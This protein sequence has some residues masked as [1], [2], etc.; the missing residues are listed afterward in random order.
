MPSVDERIVNMKMDN[1]Q[2]QS[3]ART[4]TSIFDKLKA[5]LNFTGAGKG[6]TD[7]QNKLSGFKADG[8]LNAASAVGSKFSAMSIASIAAIASIATKA[9]DVGL[10][11]TKALTIK[12]IMDGFNEYELKMD[13]I[14][15][16]LANTAKHGTKLKEVNSV[17]DELNTYADR[18]IYNFGDMTKN[19]GLFTNAGIKVKDASDMIKGFSNVA[20]ASGTSAQGA[21]GAAYQLS[22]ALSAGTIRLM[23]WRSLTNVGMGNKN[24]QEGIVELA[25]SMGVLDKAGISS[26]E[27]MSDFNGS[28]EKKWLSAD[29]MSKYLRIMGQEMTD[30]EMKTLGL[31]KAQIDMFKK[32][33]QTAFD[34]ANKV[35]TFSKLV[36]TLKESAGSGWS[37]TFGIVLGDFDQ[38]TELFTNINDVLSGSLGKMADARNDLLKGWVKMGGRD[39]VIKGLGNM[40]NGLVALMKPVQEAFRQIFPPTTAKQ[41]Y[42][43]THSFLEFTKT[44]TVGATTANNIKRTFAGVFAIFSIG[45]SLVKALAGVLGDLFGIVMS[46]SGSFLEVTAG[47]GDWLVALDQ[48][49]KKGD[50]FEKFFSSLGNIL[51]GVVAYIR[52]VASAIADMFAGF[53][54]GGV[55]EGLGRITDRLAP[56]AGAGGLVAKVWD[57]LIDILGKTGEILAPLG[58]AIGTALSGIGDAIAKAFAAGDFNS[59]YDALNSGLLIGIVLLIKK[60]LG[61]GLKIDFGDGLGASIKETFGALT[62]TLTAMQTQIQAK[63]L[64]TIAGAIAILTVS[65]VALSL[66]DSAALSKSLTAMA[67]AFGQLMVAMSIL[68]KITAVGG[69]TKIPLIAAGMIALSVAVLIL[70]AAVR[71]LSGLSWEE[72]A[73]G[74]GGVAALLLML[75]GV[76]MGLQ[77][78]SGAILRAGLA[79]IPLAIGLKILASAMKDFAAMAWGEIGKGL[80]TVAGALVAIALGMALMPPSMIATAAGLVL[81][82]ISLKIIASALQDMGGMS[83]GEIA[84]SLVVLA[85][86]LLILAGG[87]YLMTAALPGAAALVVVALALAVLAPVLILMASM[88]WE[89]IGKGMTVLAASLLILAGG[90]YLMTAAAAGAGALIVVAMALAILAPILILLGSMPWQTI[91]MGLAALAGV[92]LVIGVAGLLLGP[93]IPLILGLGAAL[94]I[95]GVGVA[96]VG[97]GLLAIA[98]AFSVF[99]A[100]ATAGISVVIGLIALVPMFMVK[101][102]EGI[103]A[104]AVAI[105]GQSAKITAAFTSLLLSLLDAIIAVAP[106]IG[107]A[108]N[109]IMATILNILVTNIPKI[110]AVGVRLILGLASAIIS[111]MPKLVAAG[112]RIIVSFLAEVSKN[113]PKIAKAGT[114]LIVKLIAAIASSQGR[115]LDAGAKMIIA[116]VRQL[117]STIRSR[118]GEMR[119]A[120]REL[121]SA[122][123]SGMTGGLTDKIGSVASAAARLARRAF[124][125]AKAAIGVNSPSKAFTWLG[126]M[127]GVGLGDGIIKKVG[128]AMR[129]GQTVAEDTLGAMKSRFANMSDVLPDNLDFSPTITPVLDISQ[130]A[131]DASKITEAL[132]TSTIAPTVSLNQASSLSNDETTRRDS[133][134]GSEFGG[135]QTILKF[136]QTNTSPTALSTVDIYRNTKNQINMAKEALGIS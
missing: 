60:F 27:I 16:I 1:T 80:V 93:I 20:A 9:V 14:Q 47:I 64:L 77:K 11:V 4:A 37:E 3:G 120:G 21:A 38:A 26:K 118:S 85:A 62:S 49:I 104:F 76:S 135:S 102:A 131:A 130:I 119:S 41:L 29:V 22:Q 128:Y 78:S 84:K 72:L 48:A 70:T 89:E 32:Q 121:A 123:A 2:L 40:F 127:S 46:G 117:A 6:V 136:E 106:K 12:P 83:W 96:L 43:L 69:F 35:R 5:S 87:L 50:V 122:I 99:I 54:I 109:V 90:L 73:K 74:L 129:A 55:A 45:W 59:V 86:S 15:T 10:R 58:E 34:A 95:L 111:N 53:Q 101:F 31:S 92:F 25:D 97:V 116:F 19:I 8:M 103:G 42:E 52:N 126:E 81:V 24:M 28:L 112:T 82:G 44:L 63:T 57:K 115:L 71:N 105:I 110:A 23:D 114:D 61:D 39:D 108:F 30:A 66:I 124:E 98:T 67:V 56:L 88:S 125:A 51:Q 36:G 18:T 17:L 68:S 75:V 94:L 91:A 33:S 107:K 65:I 7:V 79:M 113:V 13:S 132:G 100:A 134:D 133:G